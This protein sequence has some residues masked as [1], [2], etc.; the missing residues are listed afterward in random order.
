MPF[1][2]RTL[3]LVFDE[4][5]AKFYRIADAEAGLTLETEE[6][7]PA[8]GAHTSDL[9]TDKRGRNAGRDGSHHAMDPSASPLRRAKTAAASHLADVLDERIR[10]GGFEH[11]VVVAP[12][13]ALG[14]LRLAMSDAVQAKVI[15]E[16]A[17]DLTHLGQADLFKLISKEI[18]G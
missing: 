6:H 10:H 8:A 12:P 16:I 4:G 7:F 11:I 2:P 15:K 5:H 3:F 9:V 17:K 18:A 14:D 1:R 13:R